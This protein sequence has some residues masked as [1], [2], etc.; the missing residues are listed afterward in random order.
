MLI[1][2]Y[3]GWPYIKNIIYPPKLVLSEPLN[4]KII[5]AEEFTNL[6]KDG[7]ILSWEGLPSV[8]SYHL[9][10]Y[11][12]GKDTDGKDVRESIFGKDENSFM[13]VSTTEKNKDNSKENKENKDKTITYTIPK[14]KLFKGFTYSWYVIPIDSKGEEVKK[15]K[16]DEW[17]FTTPPL[18]KPELIEPAPNQKDVSLT[19]TFKWKYKDEDSIDEFRLYIREDGE[20][21]PLLVRKEFKAK[22]LK[23]DPSTQE[24]SYTLSSDEKL[25]YNITYIW[26]IEALKYSINGRFQTNIKGEGIIFTTVKE[27]NKGQND[28]TSTSNTGG[29]STTNQKGGGTKPQPGETEKTGKLVL[30]FDKTVFDKD[31]IVLINNGKVGNKKYTPTNKNSSLTIDKLNPDKYNLRIELTPSGWFCEKE[32]TITKGKDTPLTIAKSDFK[33]NVTIELTFS[34]EVKVDKDNKIFLNL[35]KKDTAGNWKSFSQSTL[36]IEITTKTYKTY[37][38][39][40]ASDEGDYRLNLDRGPEK[41]TDCTFKLSFGEKPQTRFNNITLKMEG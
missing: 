22:E 18:E 38:T 19:P 4:D 13:P 28:N 35:Q 36:R 1:A 24:F 5:T 14:E 16:S 31:L 30:N 40:T 41:N 3:F 33:I 9:Y 32:I 39:F 20:G 8:D 12:L 17:K 11:Q 6:K 26:N 29:N 34:D 10:V 25:S 37:F 27:P 23:K 7:L 2:G 21:T 15:Y